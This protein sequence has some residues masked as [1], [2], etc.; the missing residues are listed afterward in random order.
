MGQSNSSWG[1]NIRRPYLGGTD[2][3]VAKLN[4]TGILQW[5]TFLGSSSDDPYGYG[6]AVDGSK[7]IYVTGLSISSW[8]GTIINPHSGVGSNI[9]IAK[10]NS[11]G[12]LQWN[13]FLSGSSAWSLVLDGGNNIYFS[14]SNNGPYIAKLNNNGIF[15]WDMLVGPSDTGRGMTVDSGGNIYITGNSSSSWGS[16]IRSYSGGG[17]AFVA[18]IFDVCPTPPTPTLTA[19]SSATSGQNYTVSWTASANA[20]RYL[21]QESPNSNFSG[22]M[23][24]PVT[25]TSKTY[26]H[27]VT[28][29]TTYYYRI[30]ADNEPCPSGTS[31]W[32]N[33][34]QTV[35]LSKPGAFSK[36]NPANGAPNQPANP[37]LNWE[38]STGAENYSYCIDTTNNNSCSNRIN[39]GTNRTVSLTDLVA[40]TTYYWQV[41]ANNTVGYAD[42]NGETHWSFT[43]KQSGI[44]PKM[45]NIP[46]Q[47]VFEGEYFTLDLSVFVSLTD[48]D[49]IDN[50]E[51]NGNL[52]P[53]LDW[54]FGYIAGFVNNGTAGTYPLYVRAHDK[55][56]WSDWRTFNLKVI[57]TYQGKCVHFTNE[58]VHWNLEEKPA[59]WNG[60]WLVEAINEDNREER[61]YITQPDK[62]IDQINTYAA[63]GWYP[64]VIGTDIS[65]MAWIV[66]FVPM[67]SVEQG[68]FEFRSCIKI[69]NKTYEEVN[70]SFSSDGFTRVSKTM[71]NNFD[72]SAVWI[73]GGTRKWFSS[74]NADVFS[75]PYSLIETKSTRE[76]L[77]NILIGQSVSKATELAFLWILRY[78]IPAP[79]ALINMVFDGINI[80]VE[81]LMWKNPLQMVPINSEIEPT[82]NNQILREKMVPCGERVRLNGLILIDNLDLDIKDYELNVKIEY[83]YHRFSQ[84]VNPLVF[85]SNYSQKGR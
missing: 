84:K 79:I 41:R 26:N 17:D 72:Y 27:T 20:T 10:L 30:V 11:D 2:V 60:D 29:T 32:S 68:S 74:V 4:N 52:P 83:N 38:A 12:I 73:K 53:E 37:T 6:I 59:G 39:V 35:V 47:E 51:I 44:P 62:L 22:A 54:A 64:A 71:D 15:Q 8:G 46:D 3:F 25:G 34:G 63:E 57:S 85:V 48:Q 50:Y 14:G 66:R 13:T 78:S 76:F 40:G 82:Q 28:S 1:D 18:K 33:I 23:S 5:N 56:G 42:A 7:N 19:P 75:I 58:N 36:T 31:G 49:P 77:K 80:A 43:V 55:N 45:E 81:Y 21:I 24:E 9:F 65:L 69:N 61:F 16:P 70:D 67:P